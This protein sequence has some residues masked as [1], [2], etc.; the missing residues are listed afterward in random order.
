MFSVVGEIERR[1]VPLPDRARRRCRAPE[2]F[3]SARIFILSMITRVFPTLSLERNPLRAPR[4][5][6][7]ENDRPIRSTE[8]PRRKS[9]RRI[10]FARPPRDLRADK[11]RSDKPAAAVRVFVHEDESRAGHFSGASQP[12]T[13]PFTNCVFPAPR[14]PVSANTSPARAAP[15]VLRPNAIVSST[16][17]EMN[18][19]AE[20]SIA[21]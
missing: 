1:A 11:N 10:R 18:I 16:L 7:R 5:S 4:E 15:R 6:D 12:A 19:A 20:I 17:F 21:R 9:N 14:S 3:P 2:S 13:N 8:T